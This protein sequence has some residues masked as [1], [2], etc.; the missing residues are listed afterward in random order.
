MDFLQLIYEKNLILIPA[1][2][3]IGWVIKNTEK[4]NDK[5]IPAILLGL[6]VIIT[7]VL[8]LSTGFNLEMLIKS[9][10]QGILVAGASVGLHQV[11]KQITKGEIK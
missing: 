5:Y 7:P 1:L 4:I 2:M 11:K 6:G 9:I 3:I 8:D 10:V